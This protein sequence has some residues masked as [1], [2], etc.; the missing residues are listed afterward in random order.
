[1]N[2]SQQLLPFAIVVLATLFFSRSSTTRNT[3]TQ[4]F[5][6][7]EPEQPTG[8][9]DAPTRYQF[10]ENTPMLSEPGWF[11]KLIA[12]LAAIVIL[13]HFVVNG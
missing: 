7:N 3:P 9:Y 8:S 12:T 13:W 11:E 2:A 10:V 4:R 5:F 6:Q 1:M